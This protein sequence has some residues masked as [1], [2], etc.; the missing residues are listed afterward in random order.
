MKFIMINKIERSHIVVLLVVAMTV[1]SCKKG[2]FY[3]TINNDPSQLASP[4]PSSLLPGIIQTTGYIIGGDASRYPANFMQQVV[5][6]ANQSVLANRYEVS[7]DDVDDMWTAGF[8]RIMGNA[9]AMIKLAKQKGQGHY[10][11]LGQIMLAYN[12]GVTTDL[13]GNVPYTEAFSGKANLQ[14]KFDSQQSVYAAIDQLLSDAVTSLGAAD[15]SPF[16][17]AADDLLFGGDLAL[18]SRFAHSLKARFYLH[19]S[20]RDPSSYA[21]ALMEVPLGFQPGENAGVKFSGTS[22]PTQ[23]P[24]FQFNDQRPDIGFTGT[25]YTLL[26]D[27]SDP[28]LSVYQ[29]MEGEDA[30]L[31]P[32]YGSPNSTVVLM[33]YDE[34]RFI[35]AEA[36][37]M[38]NADKAAAATAYNA[39]VSANLT[40]TVKSASYA[41]TVAKTSAD[42]TLK[43]IMVQKY[44]ALFLSPEVWNDYR[45]TGFPVLT[46]AAGSALGGALPRSLLYPIGEQRYNPNTPKNT[47]LLRRVW[48]D[49][50]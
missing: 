32:L 44:F 3:D 8:Y 4:V 1:S 49:I 47:S 50:Q 19:L 2:Y 39:A 34:V 6:V 45:R 43:D 13:W 20:K 24:W 10:A 26:K 36:H 33:S 5:G 29:S 15:G 12:L 40:R 7:A 22:V 25:I 42:I 38:G 11:A 23:N 31:G 35:E 21:K 46:A 9:H 27:A 41:G 28:R 17:P 16:Q 37:L 18:W 30:L 14:P 48:W